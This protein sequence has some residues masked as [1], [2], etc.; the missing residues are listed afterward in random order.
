V[1]HPD[2]RAGYVVQTLPTGRGN[3]IGNPIVPAIKITGTPRSA[4][5]MS[6]QVGFGVSAILRRELT[7]DQAGDALID[8]VRLHRRR[9]ADRGGGARAPRVRAHE[10]VPQRLIRQRS[11]SAVIRAVSA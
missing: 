1:R 2:G 3:I 11:A 6:G 9:P 7:L 5:I 10:T 4:R 8:M